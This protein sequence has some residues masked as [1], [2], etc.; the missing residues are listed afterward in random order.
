[1]LPLDVVPIKDPL[2]ELMEPVPPPDEPALAPP[3]GWSVDPQAQSI[4]NAPA[5]SHGNLRLVDAVMTFSS[6][7]S[8]ANRNWGRV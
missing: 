6:L 7:Q 2:T 1:M 3:P 8:R 4:E 5:A